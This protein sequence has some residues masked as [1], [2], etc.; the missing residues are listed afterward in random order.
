MDV[1]KR[2]NLVRR[3]TQEV[4]TDAELKRLLEKK[5]Q[6]KGYL[7]LATTGKIHIGYFIPMMKIGDFL[8][9]NFNFTIF[10]QKIK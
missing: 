3:N 6:P 4:L 8:K 5:K 2:L 9:A 10:S 7:G 1:Q